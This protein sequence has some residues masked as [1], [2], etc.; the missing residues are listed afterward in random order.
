[1]SL[2]NLK[3]SVAKNTMDNLNLKHITK[4]R[5]EKKRSFFSKN[6]KNYV[7]IGGTTK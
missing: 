5:G 3:R 4:K 1:M 7:E 6:W 2:R